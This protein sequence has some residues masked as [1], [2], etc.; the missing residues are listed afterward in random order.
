MPLGVEFNHVHLWFVLA[1]NRC[2]FQL[3]QTY[4]SWVWRFRG[5]M[6]P[7]LTLKLV[8][9]TPIKSEFLVLI[10]LDR[11]VYT[12]PDFIYVL[13]RTSTNSHLYYINSLSYQMWISVTIVIKKYLK[14]YVFIQMNTEWTKQNIFLIF[15]KIVKEQQKGMTPRH[16]RTKYVYFYTWQCG[17]MFQNGE[18][19]RL[20]FGSNLMLIF[21]NTHLDVPARG[22][23]K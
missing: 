20:N 8:G 11:I 15:Q 14:L 17:V 2:R 7:R 5:R 3:F 19:L 18:L 1:F 23:K 22:N 12:S 9:S 4:K 13:Y 21:T 6:S 10:N 16:E